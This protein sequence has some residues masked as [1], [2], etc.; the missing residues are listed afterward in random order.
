MTQPLKGLLWDVDGTLA[1]TERLGHR[2]AFNAAFR[3]LGLP[4]EWDWITYRQLLS[5]SGGRERIAA[6][7]QISGAPTP[8]ADL[9]EALAQ[10]KARHYS[11]LVREGQ[12][13]LRPGVGRLID[14]AAA[15][16]LVQAIVTT[17]GRSAVEAL[18]QGALGERRSAFVLWICG[19]DVERKKPHPEAYHKAIA[20]LGQ[21]PEGLLAIEDSTNG[22]AASRAARVDCLVTLSA[23][24]EAEPISRFH[25]AKAVLNGLGDG[26]RP[27]RVISGP[28]CQE[29]K[30]TLSYL[31]DLNK[32]R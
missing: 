6:Y 7:A 15:A 1:E 2:L 29:G 21:P 17:S 18:A 32:R 27:V 22:L 4:W 26:E 20:A 10:T 23:A 31:Q 14:E 11:R 25:G 5:I 9:V 12:L 13:P 19:E 16:G 30:V 8:P 24:S 28:P 3:E